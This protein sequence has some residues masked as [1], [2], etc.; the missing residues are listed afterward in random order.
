M[1]IMMKRDKIKQCFSNSSDQYLFGKNEVKTTQTVT[2]NGI[3]SKAFENFVSKQAHGASKY[4]SKIAW[5][6]DFTIEMHRIL[7]QI[8]LC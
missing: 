7:V 1:E 3:S 4:Q 6:N 2:L 8:L 5:N